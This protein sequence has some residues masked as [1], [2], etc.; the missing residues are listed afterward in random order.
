MPDQEAG[1]A[2]RQAQ[3]RG[4]E[5]GRKGLKG[6]TAQTALVKQVSS[7][8]DSNPRHE[9]IVQKWEGLLLA[10]SHQK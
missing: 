6:R 2:Q 8:L 1:V 9:A 3:G 5:W 7:M 4:G 10:G